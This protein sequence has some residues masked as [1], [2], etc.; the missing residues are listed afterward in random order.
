MLLKSAKWLFHARILE[1]MQQYA[2]FDY[3]KGLMEVKKEINRSLNQ[4]ITEGVKMEGGVT[5]L[6]PTLLQFNDQEFLL[7]TRIL[8]KM[9]LIIN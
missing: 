3:S 9:K 2:V 1:K 5:N 4:E 8:G 6:R 7:R